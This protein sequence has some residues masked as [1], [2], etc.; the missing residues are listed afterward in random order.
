[1]NCSRRLMLLCLVVVA[2]LVPA[3]LSAQN[4]QVTAQDLDFG[5]YNNFAAVP[6]ETAARITVRCDGPTPIPVTLTIGNGQHSSGFTPRQ[7][8]HAHLADQLGYLLFTDAS[9]TVI[10]GDGTRGSVPIVKSVAPGAMVDIPI[11][12]R[13][14]PG[15][16]ISVGRYADRLTIHLDW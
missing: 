13:I 1:M 5:V 14:P 11:C 4:C 10:W 9:M 16:D 12:G 3:R 8:R 6:T 15:Q 7:M 2:S